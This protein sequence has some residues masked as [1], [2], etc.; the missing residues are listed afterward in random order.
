MHY[1][2]QSCPIAAAAVLLLMLLHPL[3]LP[4]YNVSHPDLTPAAKR[5][6]LQ[7]AEAAAA[8]EESAR[9]NAVWFAVQPGHK[10]PLG[11][12][13]WQR[14]ALL[15]KDEGRAWV[16]KFGCQTQLSPKQQ[17]TLQNLRSCDDVDAAFRYAAEFT[18][19]AFSALPAYNLPGTPVFKHD[20]GLVLPFLLYLLDL[21]ELA[22]ARE[23]VQLLQQAASQ[24]VTPA[25]PLSHQVY[26]HVIK[27]LAS[28]FESAGVAAVKKLQEQ[29]RH[30]HSTHD[31]IIAGLKMFG[32]FADGKAGGEQWNL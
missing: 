6:K 13:G 4:Q 3:L 24:Q 9:R 19:A 25:G 31:P 20:R 21:P 14:F 17:Q 28:L 7:Q 16:M 11:Y 8:A 18:A 12:R 23:Q 15:T 2:Q 27:P 30:L 5:A 10:L 29:G 26:W 22:N 1:A 32:K